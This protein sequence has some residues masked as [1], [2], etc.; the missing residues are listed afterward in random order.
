M[1]KVMKATSLNCSGIDD[2]MDGLGRGGNCIKVGVWGA[3]HED[4][5]LSLFERSGSRNTDCMCIGGVPGFTRLDR[6]MMSSAFENM[7]YNESLK[8]FQQLE[9][10]NHDVQSM[11]SPSLCIRPTRCYNIRGYLNSCVSSLSLK[12]ALLPTP[13][14]YS[15]CQLCF[16]SIFSDL[17]DR[18]LPTLFNIPPRLLSILLQLPN[19]RLH[20]T[21]QSA[22]PPYNS[23]PGQPTA[24][25]SGLTPFSISD[26]QIDRV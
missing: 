22:L 17:P 12:Q 9:M 14:P 13:K 26:T 19:H 10:T 1:T 7:K 25:A 24:S 4:E 11:Q 18:S 15:K 2:C 16:P 23:E 20:P 21:Y 3:Y 8:L 6:I 5:S